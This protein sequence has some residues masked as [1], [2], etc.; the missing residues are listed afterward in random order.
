[1]M[2]DV[3]QKVA[4]DRQLRE[5]GDYKDSIIN[6]ISCDL[7][8]PLNAI[9]LY[10]QSAHMELRNITRTDLLRHVTQNGLL[11]LSLVNNLIDY[12]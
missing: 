9:L 1:M 4:Y 12:N 2:F 11:I 10:V 8:T 3:T 7:K 5:I 6:F